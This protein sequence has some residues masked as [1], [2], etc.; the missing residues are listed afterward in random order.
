[1]AGTTAEGRCQSSAAFLPPSVPICIF[2]AVKKNQSLQCFFK[3]ISDLKQTPVGH[4][5]VF[6][7]FSKLFSCDRFHF[8]TR[9]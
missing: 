9:L 1:M 4:D 5:S 2:R 7:D 8:Y 6:T 3:Q